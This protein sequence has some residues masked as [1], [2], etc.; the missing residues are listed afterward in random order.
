MIQGK[1]SDLKLT[2]GENMS[3]KDFYS[4]RLHKRFVKDGE[5]RVFSALYRRRRLFHECIIDSFLRKPSMMY[6]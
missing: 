3:P 4:Y 6:S 5:T 2:N 1:M